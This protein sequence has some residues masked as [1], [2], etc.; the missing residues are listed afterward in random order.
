[1]NN[2]GSTPMNRMHRYGAPRQSRITY[3]DRPHSIGYTQH[4]GHIYR[5]YDNNTHHRTIWPRYR[6]MLGYNYGHDFAFRYHYPYYH[7]KYVFVSLGGY[8]PIGYS[9]ARY[10]WYG[11]HPYSWYGYYPVARE[12]RQDSYNYYTYNY[13]YGG[14]G[15]PVQYDTASYITPVDHTTFADIR[16]KLAAEAAQPDAPT[17]AD[18]LFE[19]AVKAFEAADFAAAAQKFATAIDLAP[20]DIIL[21]FAYSQALFAGGKYPEAAVALRSALANIKPEE[22]TVFYPRGLYADEKT[23]FEQID[24]LAEKADFFTFDADL[25]LLLGYHL[26]GI[27]ELDAAIGPLIRAGQDLVNAQASETLIKLLEQIKAQN[28]VEDAKQAQTPEAVDQ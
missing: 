17:L 23:L 21:P 26:L 22:Q 24:R 14:E 6:F 8:W 19:E 12:V 5:D 10:Y 18:T 25:Q 27:G 1:M 7:R 3:H 20:D 15:Q 13:Y 2:I 16:A 11:S 28:A 9:Y 4:Y